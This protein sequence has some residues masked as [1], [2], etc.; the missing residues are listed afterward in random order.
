MKRALI[1]GALLV[2]L[3][4]GF[5]VSCES[6]KDNPPAAVSENITTKEDTPVSITLKGSDPEGNQVTFKKL[7]DPVHGKLIGTEPNFVYTPELNY[8]GVDSFSFKVND[9]VIDSNTAFVSITI[10]SE[11]DPPVAKDDVV[12]IIEDTN[13]V[14]L[15]VLEN[16]TD[17]DGD[18]L[19]LLSA[20][21]GKSGSI[22]ISSDNKTIIYTP[23]KNFSGTDTFT[24]T[25]SDSRGG[26]DTGTVNIKVVAV[27]DPPL[28]RSKTDVSLIRVGSNFSYDVNA[29]DA[30]ADQTL[31][32]SLIT[33]PEGMTINSTTGL[34]EWEPK[35][36]QVG[37]YNVKVKVEDSGDERASDTQ[38]FAL[39]VTSQSS[40][41]SQVLPVT[42]CLEIKGKQ[43]LS[44]EDIMSLLKE[45][46]N[47]LYGIGGGE[48]VTLSFSDLSIPDG[49]VISAVI[50]CVE[51]FEDKGF[52][53]GDLQWNIGTGWPENPDIW[54]SISAPVHEGQENKSADSWEI[55]GNVDTIEKINSF[56]LQIKNINSV[57][58]RKTNIDNTFM[59]VKWY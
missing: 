30:D 52:A 14:T 13:M 27:N 4:A 24:Y 54:N 57:S 7:T 36:E 38:E 15:N 40:P 6:K 46:D 11:N 39:N 32:Y 22:V 51:H 56:E 16:D 55:K 47:K 28:I 12:E 34:I 44:P 21:E 18:Q 1:N 59:I 17:I 58:T 9:G 3:G 37:T 41:I 2:I 31:T 43:M 42:A 49:A 20:A 33:K 26:T 50:L 19:T 29:R 53:V 25:V 5:L 45:S 8:S 10:T 35:E 48:L 23:T